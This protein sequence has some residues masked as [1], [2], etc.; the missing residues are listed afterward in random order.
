[1]E[2]YLRPKRRLQEMEKSNQR[3][4]DPESQENEKILNCN[5]ESVLGNPTI[6]AIAWL[7]HRWF[8]C[9]PQVVMIPERVAALSKGWCIEKEQLEVT[10]SGSISTR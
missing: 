2:E 10:D 5:I 7:Y 3:T 4:F 1:M 9:A 8:T 6:Q